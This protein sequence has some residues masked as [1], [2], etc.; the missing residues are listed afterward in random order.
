MQRHWYAGFQRLQRLADYNNSSN[1]TCIS[2]ANLN[3]TK[4]LLSAKRDVIFSRVNG[5]Y[6]T[7]RPICIENVTANY[8]KLQNGKFSR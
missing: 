3:I 5:N 2:Q 1:N 4:D 8:I 7:L 6:S